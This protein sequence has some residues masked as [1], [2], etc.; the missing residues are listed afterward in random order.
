[1]EEAA[2]LMTVLQALTNIIA[3]MR[4]PAAPLPIFEPFSED[5]PFNLTTS[6]GAQTFADV[7]KG[8]K[9]PWDGKVSSFPYFVV[10]L[11][12][13]VAE[14]K[15]EAQAPHGILTIGGNNILTNYHSITDN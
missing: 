8:F 6:L 1:M 9:E 14:V 4:A 2:A 13:R 10:K 7:C 15:W 3:T 12:L 5:Q 11:S